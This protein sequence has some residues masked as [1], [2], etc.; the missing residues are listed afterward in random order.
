MQFGRLKRRE[1]IT[2]AGAAAATLPLAA[3]AQ[4]MPVIGILATSPTQIS[5][6]RMRFFHRGLSESGYID[7]RNTTISYLQADGR[8]DGLPGLAVEFVRRQ[9]SVIVT[10][11]FA[12]A[13]LAAKAATK[14]I[15]I[16]F[17]V[18]VDPVKI[19]LVA[20]LARPGGNLTGMNYFL[21]DL[22]GKRLGLLRE[23]VPGAATVAVLSNPTNPFGEPALRDMQAAAPAIGLQIRVLNASNAAEIDA[24]FATV[25]RERPDALMNINDAFLVNRRTQVVL[26]A[27]RHGLPALYSSR[28]W[29]EA[30][31][32]ISYGTYFSE[33]YHQL[34]AYT[35][36]ILKGANPA[37]LPVVQSTKFELVINLQ[38]A[39]ALSL[40]VPANLL[41][42]ADDV[43]E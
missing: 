28:E 41:A 9:V 16:V 24:A 11:N 15:P 17:S 14:T 35:G 19:G 13:A 4:P 22:G 32:L 10:P 21:A 18:A 26:L 33:V 30:G 29:A 43:I 42:R 20:S 39:R 25:A 38:S 8:Y 34:G 40:E 36:R 6:N 7:G 31:G 23:L 12:P 27:A 3:R 1:F 5:E 37:D 2:L